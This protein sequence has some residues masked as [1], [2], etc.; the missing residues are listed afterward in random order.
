LKVR[1]IEPSELRVHVPYRAARR[2]ITMV[3]ENRGVS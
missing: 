2:C 3:G 1:L